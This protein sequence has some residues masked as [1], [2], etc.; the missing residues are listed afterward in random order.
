MF[1]MNPK[2]F[3]TILQYQFYYHTLPVTPFNTFFF[4]FKEAL[5]NAAIGDFFFYLRDIIS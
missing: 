1:Q 2:K 3:S 4:I 5:K